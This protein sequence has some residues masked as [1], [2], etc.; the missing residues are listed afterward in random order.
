M[1]KPALRSPAQNR[2]LWGLVSA[3][4]QV[5]LCRDDA[6]GVLRAQCLAV[7]GHE[8]TSQLTTAQAERVAHLVERHLASVR[9]PAP[10]PP[11]SREPWGPRG[12]TPRNKGLPSP[13]QNQVLLALLSQAG[14][15]TPEKQ[16]TFCERQCRRFWPQTQAEAD[17]VFEGCKAIILRA[18]SAEE[19][20][21]EV[22]ILKDHPLLTAWERGFL[23]DLVAQFAAVQDPADVLT[24]HK[25]AKLAECRARAGSAC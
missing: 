5:G 2:R 6:V 17:K 23:D 14:F 15:D 8:H 11:T 21:G 19:I 25:L 7:A 10:V 4:Q 18:T 13:K 1:A 24:P 22:T 9:H 3:L 20:R 12:S 16:R